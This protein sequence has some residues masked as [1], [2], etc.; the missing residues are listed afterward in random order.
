MRRIRWTAVLVF[1][2]VAIA[3]S[4]PQPG[5]LE[6]EYSDR[7]VYG[8]ADYFLPSFL[9]RSAYILW[10]MHYVVPPRREVAT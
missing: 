6:G 1:E 3:I 9:H 5:P 8:T 10:A 4:S 2:C 7:F